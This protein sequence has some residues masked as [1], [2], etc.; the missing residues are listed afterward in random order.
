MTDGGTRTGDQAQRQLALDHTQSFIVQAPAGSGKTELLTQRYLHLL[1]TV[2]HPEEV[3]AI[4]FTQKA[5]AEMRNRILDAFAL[6]DR[7]PSDLAP[8]LQQTRELAAAAILRGESSGWSLANSPN[9]MRVLTLDAFNRRLAQS[10]P[11]TSGLAGSAS[12]ASEHTTSRY[13]ARAASRVLD[14]LVERGG[15]RVHVANLLSHMDEDGG[16]WRR[17]LVALLRKRDQW[18]PLIRAGRTSASVEL[19]GYLEQALAQLVGASLRRVSAQIPAEHKV[20]LVRLLAAAAGRLQAPATENPL[21]A[22]A[23]LDGWPA[24]SA[25]ALPAWQGLAGLLTTKNR[26]RGWRSKITVTQGFPPAAAAEKQEIGD[27]I[28]AL[29]DVPGLLDALCDV[30]ELPPA[31]FSAEQ[32]QVLMS[33]FEVLSLS[34]A[35][36]KVLYAAD[37][38]ADYIEVA[39]AAQRALGSEEAPSDLALALDYR[40]SHVLVDEMQDTSLSQYELLRKLTGGWSNTDGRT[41]FCVGDP[42]QSIYRFREADVSRFILARESGVGDVS[43]RAVE[44]SSNFRSDPKLV[45][46]CNETFAQAFPDA[47]DLTLG[48]IAHSASVA[49]VSSDP[50]AGVTIYPVLGSDRIDEA[51]AAIAAI[52]AILDQGVGDVA[53]LVR[54]RAHL[55]ELIGSLRDEGIPFDAVE[56]DRLTDAPEVRN[57]IALSRALVHDG[58]RLAWLGLL[59]GPWAAVSLEG[60]QHLT[61]NDRSSTVWEL[62]HDTDRLNSLTSEQR[63]AVTFV[64]DCV[65]R[66]RGAEAAT[67]SLRERVEK[68]WYALGGPLTLADGDASENAYRFLDILDALSSATGTFDPA[69]LEPVLEG[70]KVSHHGSGDARVQ[71]M[72]I[73]KAKGLEFDAVVLTGTGR[74]SQSDSAELL[75]WATVPGEDGPETVLISLQESRSDQTKNAL[76]A[77]LKKLNDARGDYELDR[78]LYVACTRAKKLLSIVGHVEFDNSGEIRTPS[79][80]TLLGRLWPVLETDFRAAVA[81]QDTAHAGP[82]LRERASLLVPASQRFAADVTWPTA[83]AEPGSASGGDRGQD[84]EIEFSWVGATARLIG[85]A[86]H[87]WLQRLAACQSAEAARQ[88]HTDGAQAQ[89]R[90]LQSLGVADSE[91]DRALSVV[92]RA[93]ANTL[94]DEQ[95]CWLLF[96]PHRSAAS[97]LALTGMD[98]GAMRRVVLDRVFESADGEH[99]IID[100]K[101]STH[102]GGDLQ[103]FIEN[104]VKRYRTQLATYVSFYGRYRQVAPRAGLYFPLL[105]KFVEVAT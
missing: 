49:E 72:T 45:S 20:P 101:T 36:L 22:W 48:A 102:A 50:N 1:S 21:A 104:E 81:E 39:L 100:Y 30:K 89:Q 15:H 24:A 61:Y 40:I 66:Y 70:E 27:L 28:A 35:E 95:G 32:W 87:Q 8:H 43:L 18:L 97:E 4:T 94:N 31:R 96:G 84:E 44:L 29:G 26:K 79:R 98:N 80:K 33:L 42:M 76:H 65:S 5:A 58:D 17:S 34:V 3:V 13:Y 37:D 93:I 71:L 38:V 88:L 53:V 7:D 23:G 60:L 12:V 14:W 55:V 75:H 6:V 54:N 82:D 74:K 105:V 68:L 78:L 99:W 10:L 19:R 59:R 9:R 83:A 77:Y 62:M 57:L 103:A 11:L 85:T 90:L 73:H 16:A 46:W 91:L 41:L 67:Y 2:E 86:V 92:R 63:S 47:D 69:E 56:I 52:R 25:A 64:R 51:A